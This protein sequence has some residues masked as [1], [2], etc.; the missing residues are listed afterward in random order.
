[1][2]RSNSQP[3]NL[4]SSIEQLFKSK[5]AK[6][7]EALNQAGVQTIQ[8]LLWV[9]PLRI[10]KIPA[11][12]NFSTVKIG[13]YFRG[14]GSVRDIQKRPSKSGFGKGRVPLQNISVIIKDYYS[15]SYISL[16][17]FNTYPSIVKKIE[18]SEYFGFLGKVQEFNGATQIV[19]PEITPLSIEELDSLSQ[20]GS[21]ELKIQYPTVNKISS[22]NIKKVF[23][24][25]PDHIWTNMA[26]LL[27][28]NFLEENNFLNLSDSFQIIHGKTKGDFEKAKSRLIFEEFFTEQ[29]KLHVRRKLYKQETSIKIE[30]DTEN[31]FS[32]F[33]HDLTVDQKAVLL[34]IS[35][36]LSSQKPMMRLVQGDVGCGK[37]WVAF[38]SALAVINNG[39]QVA[40]MCP[41]ESLARQHHQEAKELFEEKGIKVELLLGSTKASEKKSIYNDTQEGKIQLLIGTHSLIQEALQ[42]KNLGLAIIDEQHKFGV[43]QRIKLVSKGKGSHCLIMTATPIPRSLSLTQY[44]DLDISTIKSIPKMRKGFKTRLVEDSNFQQFLS[45]FKTRLSMGEQAYVVVPAIEENEVMDLHNVEKVHEKF[46][47]FFPEAKVFPLHGKMTPTEKEDAFLTFKKKEIDVLIATSVVEVGINVPNAT[48]MAILNPERFGLSSL[49]QLRGRVGRGDKTGFCFLILDQQV[50]KEAKDRLRFI[51]QNSDGFKIAEEDLR[52]RGQGDILGKDQSGSD[53][54]KKLANPLIH[55]SLLEMARN[56]IEEMS[57]SPDEN[58][59]QFLDRVSKDEL[60]HSTI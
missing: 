59:K 37:T 20:G 27:D 49:H 22:A 7:L 28:D 23:D 40:L 15:D 30:S 10:E 60:V 13:E 2:S 21:E 45:F 1:M 51:E 39:F 18:S 14:I 32:F 3:I 29:A 42:F 19:N 58:F 17:W 53:G 48:I 5:S 4:S 33:P 24:K 38:G 46:E 56:T 6:T 50:S 35:E 9:F 12:H 34:Q 43:A 55:F 26:E 11:L 8:D 44:G 41:T 47:N 16:K 57:D 54:I 36:D 52:N 25:I 31:I